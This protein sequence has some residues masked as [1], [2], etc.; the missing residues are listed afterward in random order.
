MATKSDAS[1]ELWRKRKQI[2]ES[3]SK[4]YLNNLEIATRKT[5]PYNSAGNGKVEGYNRVLWKTIDLT[6]ASKSFNLSPGP[7]WKLIPRSW[8]RCA[9]RNNKKGLNFQQIN[10]PETKRVGIIVLNKKK[11]KTQH[12]SYFYEYETFWEG[13]VSYS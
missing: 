4:N 1:W 2:Y 7:S 9:S 3:K 8:N 13:R 12:W 10:W 11:S 6:Q 5:T